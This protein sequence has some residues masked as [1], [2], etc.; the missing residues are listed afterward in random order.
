MFKDKKIII[1]IAI[2]AAIAIIASSAVVIALL[3]SD[4][5]TP[6]VSKTTASTKRPAGGIYYDPSQG[7]YDPNKPEY[8]GQSSDTG[9]SVPGFGTW[10]IPPKVTKVRTDFF[11]PKANK[12]KYDMTFEVRMLNDSE[13]GYEVLYTS[14]LVKAGN[15]IQ[16]VTLNRSFEKG[17]YDVILHVQPYTADEDQI[18]TNNVDI[19]FKL[20][21]K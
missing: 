8:N 13:L 12:D 5:D 20:I 21:V 18:A 16:E 17:T 3:V 9:V 1:I 10:T 6:D 15:H 7:E 14:G 11:N 2:V 4:D 19:K